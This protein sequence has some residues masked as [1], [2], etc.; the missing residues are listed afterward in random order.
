MS[1]GLMLERPPGVEAGNGN[2]R[3]WNGDG[4]GFIGDSEIFAAGAKDVCIGASKDRAKA[5]RGG[6]GEP[7]AITK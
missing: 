2:G 7:G 3:G 1:P 6:I 4:R 5:E